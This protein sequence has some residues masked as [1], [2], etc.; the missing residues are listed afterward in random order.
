MIDGDFFDHAGYYF[1]KEG[2]DEV[3]GFY[4]EHNGVYNPPPEF[5]DEAEL[6]DYYDELCGSE[7]EE[8]AEEQ[9][10]NQGPDEDS[11][12]DDQD[13]FKDLD[14]SEVNKQ[15][16]REHCIPALQWLKDQPEGKKHVIKIANVPRLA[17]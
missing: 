8:E 14:Q 7:S 6:D 10:D 1:D 12:E 5:K 9:V 15:I 2:L 17:T 16:R 4:D 13:D 11:E 3:G